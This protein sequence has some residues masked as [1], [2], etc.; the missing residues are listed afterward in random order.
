MLLLLAYF[1]GI[2]TVLAPCVLP[3]LPIILGT[4][5]Q[6]KQKLMIPFIVIASL[7][8]SVFV[9]SILLKTTT[10]FLD[11]PSNFW[12]YLSGGI[13]VFLGIVTLFP[14]LWKSLTTKNGFSQKSSEIF[15]EHSQKS[16]SIMKY[17][18]L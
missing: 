9:F 14:Y 4:S 10:L 13:L 16:E 2:L 6:G 11:V 5:L 12:K 8:I 3:L 1:S 7:S 17:I 15:A 18:F